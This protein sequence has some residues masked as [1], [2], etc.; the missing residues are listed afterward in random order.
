MLSRHE[1]AALRKSLENETTVVVVIVADE[2]A[3]GSVVDGEGTSTYRISVF[4]Q[5]AIRTAVKMKPNNCE[6]IFITKFY[7]A[8]LRN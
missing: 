3:A 1:A 7:F 8:S 5:L 4:V 2:V 6:F